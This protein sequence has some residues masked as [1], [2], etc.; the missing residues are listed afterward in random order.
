MLQS[1]QDVHS[2]EVNNQR[3]PSGRRLRGKIGRDK[4]LPSYEL[5]P[6]FGASAVCAPVGIS[7][8]SCDLPSFLSKGKQPTNTPAMHAEL[9]LCLQE[10]DFKR[11]GRITD[12]EDDYRYAAATH[13]PATSW[14][15]VHRF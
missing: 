1:V 15:G 9:L 6:A 7:H 3:H 10:S 2:P 12:R 5:R 4:V 8:S 11:P 13:L 14:L